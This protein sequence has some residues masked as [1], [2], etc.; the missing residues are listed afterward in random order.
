[1]AVAKQKKRLKNRLGEL[2]AK[3]ERQTGEELSN[4]RL[5][6]LVGASHN[7]INAIV[8]NKNKRY[9]SDV[10]VALMRFFD[11]EINEFFVVE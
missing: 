3:Y 11:V 2:M 6:E 5:A 9:D 8:R 7:T 10:V 1:M 4:T